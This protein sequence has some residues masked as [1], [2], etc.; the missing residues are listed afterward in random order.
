[1]EMG[2]GVEVRTGFAERGL[3]ID[4]QALRDLYG[5]LRDLL[6]SLD[7]G[8]DVRVEEVQLVIELPEKFASPFADALIATDA[9]WRIGCVAGEAEEWRLPD[10][11]GSSNLNEVLPIKEFGLELIAI[12]DGSIKGK[13]ENFSKK[14]TYGSVVATIALMQ[15]FGQVTIQPHSPDPVAH[16]QG[17]PIEITIP[18]STHETVGNA[19]GGLPSLP[20]GTKVIAVVKLADGTCFTI[21]GP[22]TPQ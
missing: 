2:T 10:G 15:Q 13:L 19:A 12:E 22:D 5:G 14:V 11:A 9:A 6:N 7:E 17:T 8:F 4:T 3:Q 16:G 20:A 1:M 18:Q 21:T